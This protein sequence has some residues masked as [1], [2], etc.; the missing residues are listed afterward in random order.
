MLSLNEAAWQICD[1]LAAQAGLLQLQVSSG[2]LGARLI[3]CGVKAPGGLEAG[4]RV[5]EICLAGRAQVDLTYAPDGIWPGPQVTIR[6]DWPV[7]ACMSSQ[8]AGWMLQAEKYF[9]MGSG[10]MRAAAG[11][12]KIFTDVPPEPGARRVVGF[13]ETSALPPEAV[14]ANIAS[15][16][17]VSGE[18]ITLVLARTACLVGSVQVV[19]RVVETALHKL[20][21]LGFPLENIESAMGQAPLPPVAKNDAAAIGWTN[22]AVLYGGAVSLYVRCDDAELVKLGPQVPSCASRDFGEPFGDIFKRY[23]YN[24]YKIDPL[25]FSPAMVTFHNLNT[26]KTHRFGGLRGDILASSYGLGSARPS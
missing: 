12:E 11:R 16:C 21:E 7:T 13:L 24:F 1:Q 10:P 4:R 20:H 25:L 3:D 8:Y 23:E 22:D 26:G 5:A 14:I 18:N 19:A 2:P 9:A 17:N 15:S 6:S